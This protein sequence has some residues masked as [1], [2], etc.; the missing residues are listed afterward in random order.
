MANREEFN[1]TKINEAFAN[2]VERFRGKTWGN[3]AAED[4]LFNRLENAKHNV[5]NAIK[6]EHSGSSVR[7]TTVVVPS[8]SARTV[9]INGYPVNDWLASKKPLRING[10]TVQ[11]WLAIKKDKRPIFNGPAAAPSPGIKENNSP[12]LLVTGFDTHRYDLDDFVLLASLG[13]P[14]RDIFKP[15]GK[16]FLFVEM[17]G[18]DAAQRVKDMF[19]DSELKVAGRKILFDVSVRSSAQRYKG[20]A[21]GAASPSAKTKTQKKRMGGGSMMNNAT[22][23]AGNLSAAAANKTKKAAAEAFTAARNA[24]KKVANVTIGVGSNIVKYGTEELTSMQPPTTDPFATAKTTVKEI[25]QGI[26]SKTKAIANKAKG[27][28]RRNRK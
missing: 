21:S 1:M 28:T 8:N 14:V 24:T 20:A 22:S 11:E 5:M 10:K 2:I 12:S 19:A 26:N 4:G 27:M 3:V 25:K 13:G 9:H 16:N 7:P 18:A 6:E 23:K 17:V 15:A